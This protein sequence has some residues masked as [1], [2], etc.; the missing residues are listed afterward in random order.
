MMRHGCIA[1][2]LKIFHGRTPKMGTEHARTY[3]PV[4]GNVGIISHSGGL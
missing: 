2:I 4:Q 1:I 3:A